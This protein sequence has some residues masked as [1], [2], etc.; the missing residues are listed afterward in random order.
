MTAR[1]IALFGG[2][3]DPVHYGH[4]RPALEMLERLALAEVRFIPAAMPPQ[5][6]P[7][8]ASAAQRT[9]MLEL[10]LQG[11]T[12]LSIDRRELQRPGPSYM[13]DT[14]TSLRAE[15]GDTPLCL[16]LGSDAYLGLAS[17]HR[18]QELIDL[19]HLVVMHRPGWTLA[20]AG[21]GAPARLLAQ[22]GSDDMAVLTRHPA[23]AVLLRPVTQLDIS[24]TALRTLMGAGHDPRYLLPDAVRD[25]IRAQD[26]YK[27]E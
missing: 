8:V 20:Q 25:Y 18:W 22:R 19:A 4:L 26:L 7:P 27:I 6:D 9:A 11:Q 2:T 1:P 12:G 24:A 10:A 3:F 16:L 14:L 13:V 21:A 15:L 17:W 5:R 23:G